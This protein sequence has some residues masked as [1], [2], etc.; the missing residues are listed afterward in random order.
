M[1]ASAAKADNKS[2]RSAMETLMKVSSMPLPEEFV[3]YL[4]QVVLA[5]ASGKELL[6]KMIAKV[7]QG[8]T[9]ANRGDFDI[10]PTQEEI[11]DAATR[12]ANAKAATDKAN[13]DTARIEA[14][15]REA[16]VK[17]ATEDVAASKAYLDDLLTLEENALLNAQRNIPT[18]PAGEPLPPMVPNIIPSTSRKGSNQT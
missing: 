7:S 11:T 8:E 12:L 10:P 5:G 2:L 4:D 1:S 18:N 3:Q 6:N 16:A 13:N 9:P 14:E 17:K 15:R